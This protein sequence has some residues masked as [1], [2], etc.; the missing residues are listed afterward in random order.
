[1]NSSNAISFE[2]Q[3]M[4]RSAQMF[5]TSPP[6]AYPPTNYFVLTPPT[7]SGYVTQP[8]LQPQPMYSI[9][10]QPQMV[11]MMAQPPHYVNQQPMMYIP[12][13]Q[14]QLYIPAPT[15]IS[16]PPKS[17]YSLLDS[18][19]QAKKITEKPLQ[20]LQTT[21]SN[22]GSVTVPMSK[23]KP[24]YPNLQKLQSTSTSPPST[25]NFASTKSSG[26][27]VSTSTMS[28]CKHCC[29]FFRESEN[30][31][32]ACKYHPAPY[33]SPEGVAPIMMK[34][35]NGLRWGCC[36]EWDK[37]APGCKIGRHVLDKKTEAILNTFDKNMKIKESGF[38]AKNSNASSQKKD[39]LIEFDDDNVDL[40]NDESD[41]SQS[42]LVREQMLGDTKKSQED[43]SVMGDETVV[44]HL[45]CAE[46]TL[47]GI[48][49]KYGVTVDVIR[50]ANQLATESVFEH[51][52]LDIP[53]PT[54]IPTKEELEQRLMP[55]SGR[56]QIIQKRF[57]RMAGCEEPEAKYYLMETDYDLNK[58]LQ[59]RKE[60]V[61]WE[62]SYLSSRRK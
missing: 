38:N 33:K 14:P 58:A 60:D 51:K 47:S 7:S 31:S 28:R 52:Y 39:L 15:H 55:K 36:K 20:P 44:K 50:K 8:P 13:S 27:N 5:S 32:K 56:N 23:S 19:V 49:L 42:K 57:M 37:D 9:P 24:S 10:S 59:L 6:P 53:N 61:E 3:P 40:D 41:I 46:D 30:H 21:S 45:V 25:S 62:K 16:S 1:M 35:T 48:A 54:K 12:Q 2:M 43:N 22:K 26:K 17:S 11:P 34:M 4:G 18:P 29:L